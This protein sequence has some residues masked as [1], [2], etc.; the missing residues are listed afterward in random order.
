MRSGVISNAQIYASSERNSNYAA[1]QGRL[2]FKAIPRK[3]SWLARTN[4]L[5]QWLE[6]FLGDQLTDVTGVAT[7]GSRDYDV[8]VIGYKLMFSDK[9]GSFQY[10]RKN[11]QAQVKVRYKR[12][13]KRDLQVCLLNIFML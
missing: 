3:R 2:N 11:G 7:Q 10:Y 8:W 12:L 13:D 4:D 1:I 6:V 5:N 9:G